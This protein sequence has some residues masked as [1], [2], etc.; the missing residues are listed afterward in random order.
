M[1][2]QSGELIFD[3]YRIETILGKSVLGEVYRITHLNLNV[4]RVLKVF[5]HNGN[6]SEVLNSIT[7]VN[8]SCLK[9]SWVPD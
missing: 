1:T 2:Y 9:P 8:A 7:S 6:E 5:T 4:Q 3:K